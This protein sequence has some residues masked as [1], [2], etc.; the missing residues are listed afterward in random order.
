MSGDFEKLKQQFR[1]LLVGAEPAEVDEAIE[2]AFRA[3]EAA[4]ER[5]AVITTD[6]SS[7]R[8]A[9]YSFAITMILAA[10][11]VDKGSKMVREESE[12]ARSALN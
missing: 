8:V 6:V 4:K 9:R 10:R 1:D 2:A 3:A 12:A 7:D 5:I 11:F